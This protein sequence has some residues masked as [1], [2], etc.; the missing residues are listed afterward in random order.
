MSLLSLPTELRLQIY[1]EL[2]LQ[3]IYISEDKDK[4]TLRIL[5]YDRSSGAVNAANAVET[6][7][8]NA[9]LFTCRQISNEARSEL[10]YVFHSGSAFRRFIRTAPPTVVWA[11]R[12]IE[13]RY[14]PLVEHWVH[15][16]VAVP[17]IRRRFFGGLAARLVP[18]FAHERGGATSREAFP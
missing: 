6:V 10:R 16:Y 15:N 9:I 8:W 5:G 3:T 7:N 1:G 13:I 18:E 11:I 14:N 4:D 12:I 17:A 2:P